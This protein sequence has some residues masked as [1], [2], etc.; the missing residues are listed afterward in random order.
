[1][2]INAIYLDKPTHL[3]TSLSD[4]NISQFDFVKHIFQLEFLRESGAIS[5]NEFKN[6]LNQAFCTLVGKQPK[7]DYKSLYQTSAYSG[8]LNKVIIQALGRMCRTNMKSP[9]IHILADIDIKEHLKSVRLPEDMIS[10]HEYNALV[11]E[12]SPTTDLSDNELRGIENIA[13]ERSCRTAKFISNSL[14]YGNWEDA[15]IKRWQELRQQVLKQP[16]VID[17]L[18][19]QEVSQEWQSIYLQLPELNS[20]YY[21]NRDND[22]DVQVF[23]SDKQRTAYKLDEENVRL[24]ELMKISSFHDLFIENGWATSFP[25]SKYMLTPPM[26]NDIYK[27]ALG[28]VCGKCVFEKILNTP[29]HEL[30]INEFETF[31]FKTDNNVYIDFKFWGKNFTRDAD[32]Q[33]D[34]I[35]NKMQEIKAEK[36]LIINI[37]S[38]EDRKFQPRIQKDRSIIEI[39][40]LCINDAIDPQAI[41]FI[42]EELNK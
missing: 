14:E 15:S 27:G 19:L 11:Q 21:Y 12:A 17:E 38:T 4:K 5:R 31:D 34:K 16:T 40:H 13:S 20:F 18:Q 39:P 33:L 32:E 9:N 10:I 23:F 26:F 29:L 36:V 2:D 7:Q 6:K 22:R 30:D 41:N 37:L 42:L 3:I 28:E 24:S 1:M 25:E 35:R 8:F